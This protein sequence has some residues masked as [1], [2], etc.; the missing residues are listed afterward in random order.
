MAPSCL[1]LDR[2]R[3]PLR[4]ASSGDKPDEAGLSSN[5]VEQAITGQ[6][7]LKSNTTGG[8]ITHS[9]TVQATLQ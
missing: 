6:F 8:G 2:L 9:I 4:R 7:S 5:V 1:P 3:T